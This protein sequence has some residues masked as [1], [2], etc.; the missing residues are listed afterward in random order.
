MD[1]EE[2][3]RNCLGAFVGDRE[4]TESELELIGAELQR[5]QHDGEPMLMSEQEVAKTIGRETVTHPYNRDQGPLV[6]LARWLRRHLLTLLK[7]SPNPKDDPEY[8]AAVEWRASLTPPDRSEESIAVF[9]KAFEYGQAHMDELVV[10][11]D[12]AKEESQTL[13]RLNAFLIAGVFAYFKAQKAE[14]PWSVKI[15]IGLWFVALILVA[16][17]ARRVW[18]PSRAGMDKTHEFLMTKDPRLHAWLNVTTHLAITELRIVIN[19]EARIINYSLFFTI[20]GAFTLL[21]T[22]LFS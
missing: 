11:F 18:R 2:F 1:M 20:A 12:N 17:A 19:N 22:V 3:K 4:L 7:I 13:M 8:K 14:F 16:F 6:D 5:R 10:A 9:E 15:A 21:V